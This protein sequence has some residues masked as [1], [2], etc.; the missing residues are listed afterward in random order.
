MGFDPD[1]ENPLDFD[2]DNVFTE[3]D[4][5]N[6]EANVNILC[7][8]LEQLY[9]TQPK[10]KKPGFFLSLFAILG[11]LAGD[12]GTKKKDT[13][14][15]DGDCAYCPPHYGYRYGRWY[16][17]KGHRYGCERGGNSGV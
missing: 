1:E 6:F 12:S 13:G 7:N 17:G 5:A 8:N 14:R 3:E 11:A 2:L 10:R 4:I 15:C 16:Y 9:P